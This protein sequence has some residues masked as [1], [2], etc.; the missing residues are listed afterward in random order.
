MPPPAMMTSQVFTDLI[1]TVYA[2]EHIQTSFSAFA[3]I[4]FSNKLWYAH[5]RLFPVS[6]FQNH[7]LQVFP[8]TKH[9]PKMSRDHGQNVI[10]EQ[11]L[12]QSVN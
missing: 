4:G 8:E 7:D 11:V 5:K 10:L 2:A 3:S 6:A 12:A 1:L 9:D